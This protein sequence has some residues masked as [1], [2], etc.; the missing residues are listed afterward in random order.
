[1][2]GSLEIE[3]P[4]PPPQQDHIFKFRTI[5][6]HFAAFHYMQKFIMIDAIIVC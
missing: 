4:P 2:H 5:S 6:T 3:A 1:M